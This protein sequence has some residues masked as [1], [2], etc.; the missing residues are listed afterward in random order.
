MKPMELQSIHYDTV[1]GSVLRLKDSI[2][3][4]KAEI[5]PLLDTMDNWESVSA[6]LVNRENVKKFN[7]GVKY[8]EENRL[9]FVDVLKEYDYTVETFV[10]DIKESIK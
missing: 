8:I 4:Y 10:S 5:K 6:K 1:V 2:V 3:H 7:T 9:Y